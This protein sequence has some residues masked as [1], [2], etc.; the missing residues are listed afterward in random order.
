M[1]QDSQVINKICA[2]LEK[3]LERHGVFENPYSW[4]RLAREMAN[5]VGK[6]QLIDNRRAIDKKLMTEWMKSIGV[7]Y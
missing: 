7:K 6:W 5:C 2:E 1:D 3:V 4:V